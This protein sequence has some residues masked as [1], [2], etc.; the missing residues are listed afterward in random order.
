MTLAIRPA[1]FALLASIRRAPEAPRVVVIGATALLHFLALPRTTS[2][3]DFAIV[4]EQEE[5][6]AMIGGAGWTRDKTATHR[7]RHAESQ[8][9]IDVLPTPPRVLSA[10][11]LQFDDGEKEMS[12]IGFDLALTNTVNVPVPLGAER[13]EVEVATLP[14]LLLLKI[15]AW[16]DR[17]RERTKD[18]GDIAR[19][20]DGSLDDDDERRWE[21]PLN[22]IEH[23]DQSAF[24]AGREL[25]AI[26]EPQHRT[27][28]DELFARM[29]TEAWLAVMAREARWMGDDPEA[30][31]T[32]R[33]AAFRR[34]L[35]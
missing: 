5:V 26:I 20:L 34:G 32:Q 6:E 23:E 18:L 22:M 14:A 9:I 8:S 24:F 28:L 16:L 30:I 17:P 10:G 12:M 15:V 2:D 35:G 21:E 29:E 19:I 1:H 4:A 13:L 33:L 3:V 31:A 7:W 11:R 25:G 27:K